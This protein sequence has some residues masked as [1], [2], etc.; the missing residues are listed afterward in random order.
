MLNNLDQIVHMPHGGTGGNTDACEI[1]N[2]LYKNKG[3]KLL[4]R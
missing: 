1:L 4:Y 2:L 3:D